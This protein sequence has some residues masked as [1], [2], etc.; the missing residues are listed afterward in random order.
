MGVRAQC[1]VDLR[2][3]W[4]LHPLLQNTREGVCMQ[5]RTGSARTLFILFGDEMKV[6]VT[7]IRFLNKV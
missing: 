6:E 3:G 5:I 1:G 4:A 7:M 2:W